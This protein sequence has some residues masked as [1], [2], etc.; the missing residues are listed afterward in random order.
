MSL[1]GFTADASLQPNQTGYRMLG[2]DRS[3]KLALA[4]YSL[5]ESLGSR[6][7]PFPIMRCCSSH[8]TTD[9]YA[10]SSGYHRSSLADARPTFSA[11]RSSCAARSLLRFNGWEALRILP[12]RSAIGNAALAVRTH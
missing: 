8:R 3:A 1:P 6:F 12:P 10:S 11:S 7:N 9:W 4:S 5:A 2:T